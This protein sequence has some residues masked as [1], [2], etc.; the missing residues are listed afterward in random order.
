[1]VRQKRM[2]GVPP[3]KISAR[4]R[5]LLTAHD[6]FYR[7]GIRGTGI[8][9]IIADSKVTK[10]TF[11][12]HYPSKDTLIGAYLDYRH[13]RW[14]GAFQDALCRHGGG[15]GALVPALREWFDEPGFRGCAFVNAAGEMGT[16][17]PETRQWLKRHKAALRR[18]LESLFSADA[19]RSSTVAIIALGIDGAIV[20]AAAGEPA[21]ALE[22]LSFLVARLDSSARPRG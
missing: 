16:A 11:Y 4:E 21:P 17:L 1:M 9:R 18:L 7:D 6:L 14:M 10:A 2:I 19:E 15:S 22:T 3:T 13:G 8:D 5:I 20:R 12:R